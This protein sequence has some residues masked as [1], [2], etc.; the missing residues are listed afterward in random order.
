MHV[1]D[2]RLQAEFDRQT[3]E[4]HRQEA[5][6]RLHEMNRVDGGLRSF[7]LWMQIATV[8]T[9]LESAITTKSW[10]IAAEA[11]VMIGEIREA[12]A[13]KRRAK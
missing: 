1:I 7:P 12:Q 2:E 4:A 5:I 9:A 3:L 11:L 6:H 10:N 13:P 8:E